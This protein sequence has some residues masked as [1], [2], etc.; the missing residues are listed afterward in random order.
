MFPNMPQHVEPPTEAELEA[1]K[2]AVPVPPLIA[3]A[4]ATQITG[5]SGVVHNKRGEM[6]DLKAAFGDR[7][8]A[9]ELGI[10]DLEGRFLVT[11]NPDGTV[12][13]EPFPPQA[14]TLLEMELAQ[15]EGTVETPAGK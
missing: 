12:T 15:R 11:K 7:L 3:E 1:L 13:A 9:E 2:R 4:L 5:D 10:S 6:D 8:A 14:E